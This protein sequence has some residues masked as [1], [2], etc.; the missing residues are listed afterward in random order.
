M[1][2]PQRYR[3][4]CRGARGRKFYA[5]DTQ[6]GKRTSLRTSDP[7][8][9]ERLVHAKN[10]AER[11]PMLNL[12]M[13]K[14]YLSGTHSALAKRTWRDA[15]EAIIGLKAGSNQERWKTFLNDRALTP[16]LPLIVV[17]TQSETLLQVLK[18][19]TVS[20]NVYLRRLHNFCVDMNWLLAP[21]VPKRQWPTVRFKVKRA[22][23]LEEHRK[24][25]ARETNTE[26][27]AFYTLCWHLGGSQG[28]I[29]RL[30]GEDVDWEQ[31]TVSFRRQKT[32]VPVLLFLGPDAMQVFEDLPAEGPL[33]P[34]LVT[35]R[36]S[37][38]A[39]FAMPAV[40]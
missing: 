7:E 35:L 5:V 39:C 34:H 16:L 28:D 12:H 24:I 11:Q 27:K 36:S 23:T 8:E 14:V 21:L 26:R 30:V 32:A 20:T 19:G 4:M 31:G 37:D 9:A 17:E 38:R 1:P 25:I 13:A 2:M 22:I 40:A 10:E 18:S 6:N 33:F 29:A 3:L 15:I